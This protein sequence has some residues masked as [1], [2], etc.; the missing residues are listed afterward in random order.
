MEPGAA[1][2]PAQKIVKGKAMGIGEEYV[3]ERVYMQPQGSERKKR[4]KAEKEKN[5]Q[6]AKDAVRHM[7]ATRGIPGYDAKG[8]Y[9]L[10]NGKKEYETTD[11]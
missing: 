5:A 1:D 11:K 7:R 6:A 9:Y 4:E 8:K 10:K 3:D 2:N